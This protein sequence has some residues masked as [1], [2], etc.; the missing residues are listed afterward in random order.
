MD[1]D[2]G[3]TAYVVG[4]SVVS[5]LLALLALGLVRP[6]G[7]RVPR[8]VPCLGGRAVRPVAALVPA[9]LGAAA[10]TALWTPMLLWWHVPHDDMTATGADLVGLLYL[11]L[12]AWGPLLAVLAVS[13]Q[14]RQRHASRAS[15]AAV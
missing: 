6:W 5:E 4:L 7:E 14:R 12:V 13:Y 15:R 2:A 1:L 11:P 3:G 10:L 9:Y 8:W